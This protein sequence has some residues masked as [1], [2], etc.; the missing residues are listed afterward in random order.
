MSK[1]ECSV[2]IPVFNSQDCLQELF[3]KIK[4]VFIELKLSYEIIFVN[5][6]SI[7]DSWSVIKKLA[8]HDKNV[9]GICFRKNF[10]QDNALMA[11]LKLSNGNYVI[12]MDDDLQHDPCY[13]PELLDEIS[14]GFDVVYAKYFIK[15][16]KVWKN[17]GSWFN[18]KAANII[19]KKPN[20]VYLSPYKI[21]EKGIVKDICKYNGA[22]PYVDG[23]LFNTTNCFSYIGIEHKERFKG[24]SNYTFWRSF[25]VWSHLATS[26]S[27]FPLRLAS[28]LGLISS[29][30]GILTALIFFVE[31]IINPFQPT[32]WASTII[33]ILVLGGIQLFSIGILGE[34]IGRTY[35]NINKKPQYTIKE[36]I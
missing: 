32:G 9:K 34:Y 33:S 15:K 8:L 21:I 13:I 20:D 16:Q 35:L 19:L 30:I 1:I 10:G 12:I 27:I 31:K 22:Y 26:F 29:F 24:K 6:S 25:R 18:D 23:L 5:D 2:V 17:I 3:I 36:V 4:N 14:K 28:V 11:G 7:D